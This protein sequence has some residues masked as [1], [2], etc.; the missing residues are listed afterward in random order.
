MIQSAIMILGG[1]SI[2]LIARK[3]KWGYVLGLASEPFWIITAI[4]NKQ[5]GILVLCV[6]YAYAY[7][8][9]LKNHW[10]GGE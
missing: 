6:W 5:W 10:K 9:G 7:G 3:S 2:W 4:N 8:L 1:L